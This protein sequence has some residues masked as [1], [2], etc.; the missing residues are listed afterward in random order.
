[1]KRWN[2]FIP[3][4]VLILFLAIAYVIGN[5]IVKG[6]ILLVFAAF[7][8]VSTVLKLLG[9]KENRFRDKFF[10]GI[11]LFLEIV[12]AFGA[13]LVIVTAMIGA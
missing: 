11:L 4:V 1:M 13:I 9:K 10:Y 7:L 8:I 5:A 3:A 12:L 6:I 2:D